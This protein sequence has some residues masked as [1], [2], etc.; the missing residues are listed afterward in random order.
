MKESK[1]STFL[2]NLLKTIRPDI[3]IKRE[4]MVVALELEDIDFTEIAVECEDEFEIILDELHIEKLSTVEDIIN[5]IE[6]EVKY[7]E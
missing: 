5:Y 4:T 7:K 2:I 6:T 3:E 1:V